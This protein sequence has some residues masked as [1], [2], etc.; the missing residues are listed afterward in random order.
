MNPATAAIGRASPRKL[1][2]PKIRAKNP[3]DKGVQPFQT[4][5]QYPAV[6][7]TYED[8]IADT[9]VVSGARTPTSARGCPLCRVNEQQRLFIQKKF[10]AFCHFSRNV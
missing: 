1:M 8:V 6:R 5:P 2:P 3:A 7:G 9:A 4:A 10:D